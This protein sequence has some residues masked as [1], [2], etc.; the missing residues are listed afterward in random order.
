MELVERVRQQFKRNGNAVLLAEELIQNDGTFSRSYE[1]RTVGF[2]QYRDE[3]EANT[4]VREAGQEPDGPP[5]RRLTRIHK[6]NL[7]DARPLF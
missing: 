2:F 1:F 6:I 5:R 4:W 7:K 3:K